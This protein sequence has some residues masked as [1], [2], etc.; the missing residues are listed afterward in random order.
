M[1]LFLLTPYFSGLILA[2]TAQF[3]LR[4]DGFNET[5]AIASLQNRIL[6]ISGESNIM[7]KTLDVILKT[8]RIITHQ[9]CNKVKLLYCRWCPNADYI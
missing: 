1:W 8:V 3:V 5:L 2:I 6:I 7:H 9:L 4:K